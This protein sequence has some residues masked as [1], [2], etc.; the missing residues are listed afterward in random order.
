MKKCLSDQIVRQKRVDGYSLI[1]LIIVII[2]GSIAT[3]AIV[4][5]YT[6]VFTFSHQSEIQTIAEMLAVEQM[7]IVL[8]DANGSGAGYGYAAIL[9]SKYPDASIRPT[10]PFSGYYRWVRVNTYLV[11]DPYEYK[12]IYVIVGHDYFSANVRMISMIFNTAALP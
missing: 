8:A 1:E 4:S 12:R 9:N 6:T 11:G 3:P 2:L 10:G 5:M 7:E